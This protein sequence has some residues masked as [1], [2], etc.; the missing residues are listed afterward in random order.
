MESKTVFKA[1]VVILLTLFAAYILFLGAEIIITLLI[2]IIIASAVRPAVNGLMRIKIPEG[3]AIVIV[4]GAMALIIL[5]VLFVLIPPMFNQFAIYVEQDW[6]LASRIITANQIA[7]GYIS[8]FMAEDV[9]LVSSDQIRE[10]VTA[11]VS[12]FRAILPNLIQN[13]GTIIANAVLIFV[14]GAYWLTS[15]ISAK[16]FILKLTTPRYR[17]ETRVIINDIEQTLGGFVRS[18]VIISAI[19]TM[20]NFVP[21][22]ILGVPNALTMAFI[23]GTMTI[24]PMVG[25]LIGGGVATLL[26]L[27]TDPPFAIIVLITFLI[28]SQI[29]NYLLQPRIMSDGVGMNPLLVIVYTS[30]GFVLSGV[31]GALIAIPIMG[32]FHI[33]LEHLIIEP[34][35]AQMKDDTPPEELVVEI[36]PGDEVTIKK[37]DEDDKDA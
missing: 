5:T 31:L 18:A 36:E 22:Y 15:H 11:S 16:R 8:D 37:A 30:I 17:D 13:T 21:M 6:R 25:G 29:E 32:A 26:T 3:V 12:E 35:R 34:Y 1:T 19:V 14:M 20:L 4:Y 33:L 28:V 9:S 10:A 2:A 23:I 7:E 27:I 24:I